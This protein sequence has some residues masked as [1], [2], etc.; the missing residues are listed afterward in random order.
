MPI[1]ITTS[2]GLMM[3]V[4]PLVTAAPRRHVDDPGARRRMFLRPC[5]EWRRCGPAAGATRAV[6]HV[7]S[8]RDCHGSAA[9]GLCPRPRSARRSP[10][11]GST[12]A[13]DGY[14]TA[15][16]GGCRSRK[17]CC[18]RRGGPRCVSGYAAAKWGME[19]SVRSPGHPPVAR[20]PIA[21]TP[22]ESCSAHWIPP[23]ST[24]RSPLHGRRRER[25]AVGGEADA[26]RLSP[27]I[28]R[29]AGTDPAHNPNA[30]PGP[31][32]MPQYV[33]PQ[34][35]AAKAHD[36]WADSRIRR[37]LRGGGQPRRSTSAR[38]V[39]GDRAGPGRNQ[40]P[41]PDPPGAHRPHRRGRIAPVFAVIQLLGLP[42][43]PVAPTTE[44]PRGSGS[45]GTRTCDLRRDRPAL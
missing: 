24:P 20:R 7:G 3:A 11:T 36:A 15:T 4:Y 23:R 25:A 28:Q 21:P 44:T 6:D 12:T 33:I 40:R 9:P 29:L 27:G 39:P 13:A 18:C 41:L 32:Y 10:S 8:R 30:P 19:S 45:D 2:S 35:A 16:I 1:R 22:R 34:A 37:G 42:G 31:A 26:A 14:T 38:P 43:P 5:R 17:R